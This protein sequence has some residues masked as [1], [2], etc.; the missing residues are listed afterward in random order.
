MVV[1]IPVAQGVL[2]W[3]AVEA[4]VAA[5]C[6]SCL[7][8]L[9]YI[10]T[11]QQPMRPQAAAELTAATSSKTQAADARVRLVEA[12]QAD[13]VP[14]VSREHLQR[15]L[16]LWVKEGRLVKVA[17]NCFKLQQQLQQQQ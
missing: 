9:N 10:S 15:Q 6:H 12:A 17:H 4:A 13:A 14:V 5:G 3:S 16:K 1:C 8:I 2:Q 11:Q 7:V